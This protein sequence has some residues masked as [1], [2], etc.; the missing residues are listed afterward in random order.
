MHPSASS[1]TDTNN[2]E[3]RAVPFDPDENLWELAAAGVLTSVDVNVRGQCEAAHAFARP[4]PPLPYEIQ[5]SPGAD[6][7][8]TP[9]PPPRPT[10]PPW[11]PKRK[12]KRAVLQTVSQNA[13]ATEIYALERENI[14]LKRHCLLQ[15]NVI[16]SFCALYLE[17]RANS[18]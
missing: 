1:P 8:T 9:P 17:T 18:I 2:R 10:S 11:A 5:V 15:E 4:P 12:P 16:G 13:M 14:N 7:P 6:R 3:S